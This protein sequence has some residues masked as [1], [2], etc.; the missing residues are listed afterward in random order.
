MDLLRERIDEPEQSRPALE[1]SAFPVPRLF[2]QS[3]RRNPDAWQRDLL[4]S[5][6]PRLPLNCARQSGKSTM[7][8]ILALHRAL[9]FSGSLM[10]ML[11]PAY[12]RAKNFL[13]K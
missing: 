4:R 8:A 7:A 2:R 9:Y 13:R 3:H 6:S 1:L 12:A 10:V 11:A 5:D